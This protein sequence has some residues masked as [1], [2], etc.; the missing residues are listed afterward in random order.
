[1]SHKNLKKYAKHTIFANKSKKKKK[2]KIGERKKLKIEKKHRRYL[3]EPLIKTCHMSRS[4]M[5][6][7]GS[8]LE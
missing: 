4:L 5:T 7:P 2:K 1:M 6:I 3:I 8:T